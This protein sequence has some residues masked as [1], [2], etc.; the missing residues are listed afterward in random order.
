MSKVRLEG[1]MLCQVNRI[2]SGETSL[3]SV[4]VAKC[5]LWLVKMS[6]NGK[7]CVRRQVHDSNCLA[8]QVIA[9][10]CHLM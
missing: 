10:L 1:W 6:W 2:G 7:I 3:G 8:T 9:P 4:G 5:G